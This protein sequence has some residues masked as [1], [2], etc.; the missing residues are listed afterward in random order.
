MARKNDKG[1]FQGDVWFR[2]H[3]H[4]RVM[5]S[6]LLPE[7]RSQRERRKLLSMP[8]YKE[9]YKRQSTLF[10]QERRD[11]RAEHIQT[12][13]E[14]EKE[15]QRRAEQDAIWGQDHDSD[16]EEAL[17]EYVRQCAEERGKS[18]RMRDVLG[19]T[20]ISQRF[21]SWALV[22]TLAGLKLPRGVEPPSQRTINAYQKQHKE[23]AHGSREKGD[24]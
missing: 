16:T 19:G 20:Y 5:D 9:E 15:N 11:K 18:P 22:L 7:P 13:M 2:E 23:N 4:A 14:G 12:R 21:G 6:L 10:R 24:N 17:L 8:V 1:R 3:V